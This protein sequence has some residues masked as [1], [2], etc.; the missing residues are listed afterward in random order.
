ML[1]IQDNRV[2]SQPQG[3]GGFELRSINI[4]KV[5]DSPLSCHGVG[6]FPVKSKVGRKEW[7]K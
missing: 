3:H 4:A 1:L 2:V 5:F 6:G 7:K